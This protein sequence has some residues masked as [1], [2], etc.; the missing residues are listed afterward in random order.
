[1]ARLIKMG[2]LWRIGVSIPSPETP[3]MA[4]R[5]AR[6]PSDSFEPL[7]S[8]YSMERLP[9]GSIR[10]RIDRAGQTASRVFP[11]YSMDKKAQ[12]KQL[13]EAQS[14]YISVLE[15]IGRNIPIA[16]KEAHEMTLGE[17]IERY[18]TLGLK[19]NQKNNKKD[20]DRINIVLYDKICN[21]KLISI[22]TMEIA[23]YRNRLIV[24]NEL[25]QVQRV[26]NNLRKTDGRE[27]DIIYLKD[28][29]SLIRK[30]A[31]ETNIDTIKDL[32]IRIE[33]ARAKYNID[34]AKRTTIA[35]KI[36]IITRTLKFIRETVHGVPVVETPKLP[37]ASSGRERRLNRGELQI[38]LDAAK[39]QHPVI[40][41]MVRF[42]IETALRLERIV[43][44]ST[45]YI[46]YNANG[47]G[48]IV[49]PVSKAVRNKR[50]GTIPI[51]PEIEDIIS[52][53]Y[54]L[55]NNSKKWDRDI[56]FKPF[57][58]NY[59]QFQNKWRKIKEETGI[60]DIHFH[61]LRHEATSRLFE[62]G[63]DAREVA[64]ITGHST[65]EM[66]DRYSHY[67]VDIIHDKLTREIDP[68]DILRNIKVLAHKW[69]SS[70]GTTD[71][72]PLMKAIME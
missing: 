30:K 14:Y 68:D 32:D 7:P 10:V 25:L 36:Q 21:K 59:S 48:I 33:A 50:T 13:S 60:L 37:K 70:A 64:T 46:R 17:A 57:D 67:S 66:L 51:T 5:Q 58:I 56:I 44:F 15:K 71:I 47:R 65:N 31:I 26:I 20:N 19:N 22:D 49:F 69:R 55:Q 43:T 9:S 54:S 24:D 52:E 12:A 8:G 62:K 41:L 39:N 38:I 16:S 63:L 53:A 3:P 29:Q 1:M 6:P 2:D 34:A 61:D 28:I 27:A 11:L 40:P 72:T 18:R 23:R 35:N 4:P 42:A 45:E